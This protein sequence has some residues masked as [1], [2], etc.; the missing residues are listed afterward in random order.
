M[1]YHVYIDFINDFLI[2]KI[3]LPISNM[4]ICPFCRSPLEIKDTVS[5]KSTQKTFYLSEC[6]RCGIFEWQKELENLEEIQNKRVVASISAW[7][8]ENE[9]AKITVDIFEKLKTLSFL[10]LQDKAER[11]LRY[12]GK[13][14]STPGLQF[15]IQLS[16][17]KQAEAATLIYDKSNLRMNL[18]QPHREGLALLGY[19]GA[20]NAD[21]LAYLLNEVLWNELKLLQPKD[22]E[23]YVI[24]PKGW[25]FLEAI[26]N[27]EST[28]GFI[29]MSFNPTM[30][31]LWKYGIDSGIR[32]AGYEPKRVDKY[33]HN[34]KVDDEII[35]LIRRSRFVVADL[36]DQRPS[37]YFEAGFALGLGLPVFWTCKKKEIDGKEIHFDTRQ[38]NIIPWEE[39]GLQDFQKALAN[40]IEATIGR[41]NYQKRLS[42]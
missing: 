10:G 12:F 39:G 37:V 2:G 24:T 16:A 11:L 40:R 21:E 29:A 27:K 5:E 35:A 4:P 31:E 36:T 17:F 28:M 8:R 19:S 7:I 42:S 18:S 3:L 34:N 22:N 6:A 25:V 9:G 33:E 26:P 38:Y 32:D 13:L 1:Q 14:H 23:N 15:G 30:L 41:G 20:L